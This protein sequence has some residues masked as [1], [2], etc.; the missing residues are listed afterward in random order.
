MLSDIHPQPHLFRALD[1]PE[2]SQAYQESTTSVQR[3]VTETMA[4]KQAL[5]DEDRWTWWTRWTMVDPVDHGGRKSKLWSFTMTILTITVF[6]SSS[7]PIPYFSIFFRTVP[8]DSRLPGSTIVGLVP[9]D[10]SSSPYPQRR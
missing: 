7:F 3:W 9:G 1:A 6:F 10:C 5:Q 8:W 2:E 4:L